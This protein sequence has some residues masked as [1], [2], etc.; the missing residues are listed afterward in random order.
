MRFQDVKDD[1]KPVYVRIYDNENRSNERSPIKRGKFMMD[2]KS[3]AFG[4]W[5]EDG[6]LSGRLQIDTD[7]PKPKEP[8]Q[9]QEAPQQEKTGQPVNDSDIPF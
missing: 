4:L 3:Y 7:P 8:E 1:G 9:Q 5:Q 2:G 6:K